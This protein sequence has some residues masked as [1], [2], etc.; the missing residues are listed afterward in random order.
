[1]PETVL[2]EIN[3]GMDCVVGMMRSC[4]VIVRLLNAGPLSLRPYRRNQLL[5]FEMPMFPA[6]ILRRQQISL[7]EPTIESENFADR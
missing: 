4:C 3:H 1:M 5:S 7:F 6:E 2:V